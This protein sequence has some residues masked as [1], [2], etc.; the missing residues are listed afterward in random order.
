[1]S[2]TLRLV[3]DCN[4][5]ETARKLVEV[6][7]PDNRHVPPDQSFV[8]SRTRERVFL[9]V[10]SERQTAAFSSVES[11]LNDAALFQR[12]WLLSRARGGLRPKES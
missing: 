7:C 6:L 3:M 12:V 9:R 10:E 5:A 2:V 8:M 4:D 1:M 11:V